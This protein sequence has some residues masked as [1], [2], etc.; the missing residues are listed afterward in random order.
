MVRLWTEAVDEVSSHFPGRALVPRGVHSIRCRK[1]MK[2][3][4]VPRVNEWHGL[5]EEVRLGQ[6]NVAEAHVGPRE[7]GKVYPRG[8]GLVCLFPPGKDITAVP[9][10][11]VAR[12]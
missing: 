11:L 6:H 1:S 12:S 8:S 9:R 7:R 10:I 5:M 3:G 2:G 4:L